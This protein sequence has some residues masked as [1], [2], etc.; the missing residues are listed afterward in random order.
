MPLLA[1]AGMSALFLLDLWFGFAPPWPEHWQVVLCTA[2]VPWGVLALASPLLAKR[3]MSS[4]LGLLWRVLPVVGVVLAAYLLLFLFFVYDLGSPWDRDV[5]GWGYTAKAEKLRSLYPGITN[6]ELLDK[7]GSNVTAVFDATSLRLMRFLLLT[8]WFTTAIGISLA[9]TVVVELQRT[10][11]R[12]LDTRIAALVPQVGEEMRIEL[13]QILRTLREVGYTEGALSSMIRVAL[14]LMSRIYH[15]AEQTRPSDN[16]F[17]CIDDAEKK[18]LLPVEIGDY[19]DL[20]RR[21]GN[22]PHHDAETVRLQILDAENMLNGFLRVLQWF[23]CESKH[24][25]HR[26]QTIYADLN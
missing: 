19:L 9:G 5:G 4:L 10:E 21:K 26:L 2:I 13:C 1:A 20:I 23:H 3:S 25:P 6:N 11:T 18:G 24:N 7:F 22:K 12:E 14:Q 8:V 17:N 15:A 16:L